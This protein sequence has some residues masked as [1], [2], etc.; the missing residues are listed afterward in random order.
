MEVFGL[1]RFFA[2]ARKSQGKFVAFH[3]RGDVPNLKYSRLFFTIF[4]YGCS[5]SHRTVPFLFELLHLRYRKT[6]CT[7]FS[8][9]TFDPYYTAMFINKFFAQDKS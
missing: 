7:S 1:E 9:F 3:L 8:G 2:L 6:K 4:G 5:V